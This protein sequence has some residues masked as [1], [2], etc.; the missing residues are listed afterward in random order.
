MSEGWVALGVG[1]VFLTVLVIENV[2]TLR[3]R[4]VV[5]L[6]GLA[7]TLAAA[8]ASAIVTDEPRVLVGCVVG[9]AVLFALCFL[10]EFA[11]P[12]TLGFGTVKSSALLGAASGSLGQAPWLACTA[13]LAIATVGTGLLSVWKTGRRLPSGPALAVGLIGAVVVGGLGGR[14]V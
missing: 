12:S 4:D 9:A 6:T 3:L 8:A 11:Q 10:V 14:Q 13:L 2:R 5:S 1:A 7:A